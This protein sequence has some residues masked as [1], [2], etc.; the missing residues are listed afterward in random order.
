MK[1]MDTARIAWAGYKSKEARRTQAQIHAACN[2]RSAAV[3]T[4]SA[5]LVAT[6]FTAYFAVGAYAEQKTGATAI[7]INDTLLKQRQLTR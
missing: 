3:Y 1:A 6:G 2:L 5:V 7:T 4:F